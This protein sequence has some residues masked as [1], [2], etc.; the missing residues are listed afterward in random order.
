MLIR[1]IHDENSKYILN[2]IPE[3]VEV[4]IYNIDFDKEKKK[5]IPIMVR[6]GTRNI[7]LITLVENGEETKVIWSE[8]NPDWEKEI[9]KLLR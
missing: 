1:I 3:D 2:Y 5:A 6:N 4:E 8:T 9:K 7:P